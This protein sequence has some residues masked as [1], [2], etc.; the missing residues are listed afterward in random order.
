MRKAAWYS[1]VLSVLVA[2]FGF[3]DAAAAAGET[4]TTSPLRTE[5]ELS[6]YIRTGRYDEVVR[7]CAAFETAHKPVVR[8]Q[9]FGD[10]PEGRPMLAL[11]AS[12]DGTLDPETARARRRPVVLVQGGI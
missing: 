11:V 7:L 10:T 8:C 1:V 3:I 6:S 12:A 5:G 2:G 4:Q 9:R